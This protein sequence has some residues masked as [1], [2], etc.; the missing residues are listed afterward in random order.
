MISQQ[1]YYFISFCS[2]VCYKTIKFLLTQFHIKIQAV[3]IYVNGY[4]DFTS[5]VSFSL[6]YIANSLAL[7]KSP[8]FLSYLVISCFLSSLEN[9]YR[10][11]L[12]TAAEVPVLWTLFSVKLS[13][14]S[15]P[16][17]NHATKSHEMNMFLEFPI[18]SS[19]YSFF[20]VIS[21]SLLN[22]WVAVELIFILSHQ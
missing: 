22:T 7:K 13:L 8:A 18:A 16:W 1:N 15:S 2:E 19:A 12:C 14:N 9:P 5:S 3:N 17:K 21:N 10:W 6:Y 11:V 4:I 20:M